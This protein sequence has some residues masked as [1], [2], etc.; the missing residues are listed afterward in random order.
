M[1]Q[2]SAMTDWVLLEGI[3]AKVKA[4]EAVTEEDVEFLRRLVD[5]LDARRLVEEGFPQEWTT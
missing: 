3:K 2:M 4:G 1:T 5:W